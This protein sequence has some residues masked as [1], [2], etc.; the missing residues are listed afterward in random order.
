MDL[1]VCLSYMWNA[2]AVADVSSL[3]VGE[4]KKDVTANFVESLESVLVFSSLL[5]F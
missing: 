5:S 4:A 1:S 2:L 3:I